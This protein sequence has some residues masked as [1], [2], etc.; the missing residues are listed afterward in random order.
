MVIT[1]SDILEGKNKYKKEYI[2]AFEDEVWL[3]KL[4]DPEVTELQSIM[5]SAGGSK[6]EMA[7]SNL[8]NVDNKDKEDIEIRDMEVDTSKAIQKSR[9]ARYTAIAY[10]L[11][12]EK[13]GDEWTPEEVK[14]GLEPAAINELAEKIAE[15][16]GVIGMKS[17]R[18]WKRK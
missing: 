18:G 7:V 4:T 5:A 8:E 1:K 10:S 3:R 11:S 17:F 12:N 2:E 15:F 6:M 13:S 9:E 16:S 14:D